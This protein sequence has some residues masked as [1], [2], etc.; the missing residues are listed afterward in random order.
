M[1]S[2]DVLGVVFG[3]IFADFVIFAGFRALIDH[4][5]WDT[6]ITDTDQVREF[7]NEQQK[8]IIMCCLVFAANCSKP[9]V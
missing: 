1:L 9:P 2:I 3:A 8:A 5:L 7:L 4:T 6:S